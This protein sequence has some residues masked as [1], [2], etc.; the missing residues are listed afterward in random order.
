MSPILPIPAID[1]R[2]GRCVRLL[3]G[4]FRRETVYGNDPAEMAR[5]WESEGAERI[6]IVDLDGA[7]DGHRTNAEPIRRAIAAVRVPV[8]VGGGVRTP[9]IARQLLDDGADRVIVGTAAAQHPEQ[10]A[11]WIDELGA[12]RVIV[13]VDARHG[14]VATHGWVETTE[15]RASEFC[16]QLAWLGIVRVLFTDIDRDGT[17]H[18]PNIEATRELATVVKVIASGGVSTTEHLRQLAETGAEAVVIGTALYD[19]RLSL[20]DALVA[21]DVAC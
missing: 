12:E 8:Q 4:D 19:G 18:G 16:Q 5:R 13:G 21:A 10:L 20:R 6:H 1:I 11:T 15:L 7:R 14:R 17:L 2:S 3:R 9:D